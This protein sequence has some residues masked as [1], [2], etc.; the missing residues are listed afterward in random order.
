[1]TPRS[2]SEVTLEK[3]E[4]DVK[5]TMIHLKINNGYARK[6]KYER[7]I[8]FV[9]GDSSRLTILLE[10]HR[11]WIQFGYCRYR[12][13]ATRWQNGLSLS[14]SGSR[15][16]ITRVREYA[17]GVVFAE[18]HG[19]FELS[20]SKH[21]VQIFSALYLIFKQ[22]T[23]FTLEEAAS[24]GSARNGGRLF[25]KLGVCDGRRSTGCSTA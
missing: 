19:F 6:A 1:M 7:D 12:C 24:G 5:L 9:K 13:A 17:Q 22:A 21:V 25:D 8:R 20:A 15:H 2:A 4:D 10:P 3:L 14:D 18:I 16:S 23:S 11:L